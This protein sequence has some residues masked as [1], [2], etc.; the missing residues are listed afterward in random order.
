MGTYDYLME[1]YE[2]F[3]KLINAHVN[4]E[5]ENKGEKEDEEEKKEDKEKKVKLLSF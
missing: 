4:K 3:S 5:E 2:A 1:N